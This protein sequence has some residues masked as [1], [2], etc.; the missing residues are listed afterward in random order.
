MSEILTILGA[1]IGFALIM[2]LIIR[3]AKKDAKILEN[4][5]CRCP[6]CKAPIDVGTISFE[7][8]LICEYC[9]NEIPADEEAT[10]MG[11]DPYLAAGGGIKGE[12]FSDLLNIISGKKRGKG[13]YLLLVLIVSII[14]IA[15]LIFILSLV[16]AIIS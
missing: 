13:S 14:A 7:D 15:I 4:N 1:V 16:I 3:A 6:H 8:A 12:I 10:F 11:L 5:Q 9:K 2:L